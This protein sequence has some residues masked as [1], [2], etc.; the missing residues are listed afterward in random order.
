MDC[1]NSNNFQSIG[2]GNKIDH[3]AIK[4]N[5]AEYLN[6]AAFVFKRL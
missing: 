1:K 4:L 3:K 5:A 2:S 6:S